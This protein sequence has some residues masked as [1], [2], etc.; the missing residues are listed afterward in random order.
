MNLPRGRSATASTSSFKV[1]VMPMIGP[2]RYTPL[3]VS[4]LLLT[5]YGRIP[6]RDH[7]GEQDQVAGSADRCGGPVRGWFVGEFQVEPVFYVV[8]LCS[9]WALRVDE[10]SPPSCS[11]FA[12]S[13]AS[14]CSCFF[15][16]SMLI[17]V[18]QGRFPPSTLISGEPQASHRVPRGIIVPR[19]GSG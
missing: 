16:Q 18:T 14:R 4:S 10:P 5:I 15:G 12:F 3:T 17:H 6:D 8:D 9:S 11:S 2:K 7:H 19:C 13:A 1:P